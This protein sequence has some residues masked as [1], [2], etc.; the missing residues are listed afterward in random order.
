MNQSTERFNRRLKT[1]LT[2]HDLVDDDA[3]AAAL[4]ESSDG[5]TVTSV[6][7]EEGTLD[8]GEYLSALSKET[9]IPPIDVRKVQPTDEL[10]ET[11]DENRAKYFGVIP[12]AQIGR[13]LSLAVSDP[14][15]I[16][17]L[18]DLSMVTGCTIKPVLSTDTAITGVMSRFYDEG[19]KRVQEL[20]DGMVDPELELQDRADDDD[21]ADLS[22]EGDESPVV[23]LVNLIVYQGIRDGSSDIHIEPYDRQV[24]VRYRIDGV[25]REAMNPPFK[26]L[27]AMVS[28]I[29]I[30]CGLDIAERRVPQDGK[31]QL[32][33]EGRRIDFRVSTLPTVHG[34]KV[35]L[36][37]LDSSSLALELDALGFETKALTD[38]REAINVPYGMSL[39][40]G[41]TGSGK[42]TTL[43]SCIHEVLSEEENIVT[44]ED[45]VEYQVAGVNQ[46]PVNVKR[47]LTFAAALRSILRQ[48]P[49]TVMI[50]EIRDLETA[51]IAIKAALTGHV[52]FSTLHT[53]DAPSTVTRIVDMG[54][55][56]FLVS[57]SVRCIAA[58]RLARRLCNSCKQPLEELPSQERLLSLGFREEDMEGLEIFKPVG[59]QRCSSGFKGRFA[60]LETMPLSEG[61]QRLIVNGAS[62]LEIKDAA[63]QEGMITLRRCGLLNVM[64]GKTSLEEVIRVTLAD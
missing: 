28:R 39:V 49:D 29:K 33:V 64:R 37:I 9:G 58:Q 11:L 52:V 60:L 23:K 46:V 56:P 59:C 14:F 62:A 36:R 20:L 43:Y 22:E 12:V 6:L 54:I 44:V 18:D 32:R 21:S 45:P 51:E 13:V 15:D 27:S 47:G 17:K 61:L 34:E 31:F 30:M 24:R 16:V 25:L 50:G 35:V 40:T 26:M 2:R 3:I 38:I 42:S 55:D 8:E 19:A 10:L 57:S 63:L 5:R 48:D 53:N 4:Q 1:I 41:P 7:F